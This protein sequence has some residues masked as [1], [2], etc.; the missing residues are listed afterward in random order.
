[1]VGSASSSL[2]P[3]LTPTYVYSELV[4]EPSVRHRARA[5]HGVTLPVASFA[6]AVPCASVTTS[7]ATPSFASRNTT[8]RPA[9]GPVVSSAR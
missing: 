4:D 8:G 2:S 6:I 1:M 3:A 5:N 7:A 9:S